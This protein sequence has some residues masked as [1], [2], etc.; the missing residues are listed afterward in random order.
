MLGQCAGD[1]TAMLAGH[2]PLSGADVAALVHVACG[3]GN[4]VSVAQLLSL[5]VCTINTSRP[6]HTRAHTHTQLSSRE[7]AQV[8]DDLK[9]FI[10]Q[11]TPNMVRHWT[12]TYLSYL[13]RDALIRTI[14]FPFDALPCATSC[15]VCVC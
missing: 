6:Q 8:S 4:E 3:G 2:W 7:G 5:F 10:S 11:F 15:G 14:A 9:H 12:R 13:H 1:V